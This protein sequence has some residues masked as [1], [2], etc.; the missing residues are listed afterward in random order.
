MEFLKAYGILPVEYDTIASH[1]E[2]YKSTK[3]KVARMVA[4][5]VLIRLKKGMFV[6][7]PHFSGKTLSLELIA[8]CLYGPSYVSFEAALSFH[9]M[10]PERTYSM[11]SAT[12]RRKKIFQTQVGNFDYYSVPEVYYSIGIQQK[13]VN[14]S[15]AF[16][17][18]GPEK[19]ICDQI[20]NTRGLRLQSKKA[21]SAYLFQD[22]RIDLDIEPGI[23]LEIIYQCAETGYKKKE[24]QLIY[25]VI[26]NG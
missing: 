9:G 2:Q 20:L 23:D 16:L 19:A 3:D 22:I 4:S 17:I 13:I 21:V 7:A 12:N 25:Q 18:A 5:G 14:D 6:I 10:I 8:N 11:M 1:L 15:Y 24:L 26:K